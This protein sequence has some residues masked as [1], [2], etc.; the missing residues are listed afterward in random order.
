MPAATAL[1]ITPLENA[2]FGAVVSLPEGVSDPSLL[3]DEDFKKLKE[4]LQ[5]NLVLVIPKQEELPPRSQHQL[6]IRF[7]PSCIGNYG[8]D[9]KLFHHKNSV[10]AKDG[11][12]FQDTPE[13]IMVGNS[14][15]PAGF[16]PGIVKDVEL[17]HPTHY[18]FHKD[19]LTDEQR[20]RGQTRFFRWHID[21][22]LYGL[23]PPQ[24]TTL[25]GCV[26]PPQ[27]EKQKIIYEDT[28]EELELVKGSTAF[29]SG[30][31]AFKLLSPEDQEMALNT[32]VV[33][34]P[35]PYIYISKAK[36]TSDGLTM[37]SEGKEY[38]FEELPEWEESK[39]K[40]LPLVWTNP[41]TGEHHL[42]V[43]GCCVYQLINNKTGEIKELEEA[44]K[45][46]HRLMR[47]AISPQHIYCHP[48]KEGDLVIFFNRGLWHSVTGEFG[49]EEKRMMHQCNVAS[50]EDP[51]CVKN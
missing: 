13:V 5:K 34:A 6:T 35:H 24:V 3:S 46:V 8:H 16:Q 11:K 45:E 18:T 38:P 40:K 10:L 9:E 36:A 12:C 51:I 41:T 43:H 31:I 4:G 33:Y 21:A 26:V 50:G 19:V 44:R 2:P 47:P 32:T 25:L 29:A 30:A 28:N 27:T 20:E 22:A 23:S 42:Q 48:W 37:V 15:F 49:P 1:Q 17:E 7:D 14:K 39:I